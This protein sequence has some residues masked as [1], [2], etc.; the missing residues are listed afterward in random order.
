[1]KATIA[2]KKISLDP[3]AKITDILRHAFAIAENLDLQDFKIWCECE[4]KGYYNT[5]DENLP[6]YR[7]VEGT[8]HAMNISN[9][10]QHF[11]ISDSI[12]QQIKEGII[13]YIFVFFFFF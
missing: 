7:L 13:F 6:N 3:T 9:G 2:L 4:L 11:L 5:A 8:L 1:M 12:G 10:N